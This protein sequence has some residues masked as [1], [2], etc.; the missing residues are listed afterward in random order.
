M[1]V[2][3]C[4]SFPGLITVPEKNVRVLS[5]VLLVSRVRAVPQRFLHTSP[6]CSQRRLSCLVPEQSGLGG[7]FLLFT[8]FCTPI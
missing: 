3:V 5:W 8:L 2:F 1:L 6:H 7:G 4:L